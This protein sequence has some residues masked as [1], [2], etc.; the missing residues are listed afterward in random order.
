MLPA[1][2]ALSPDGRGAVN[3]HALLTAASLFAAVFWVLRTPA[4]LGFRAGCFGILS[5]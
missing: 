2:S 1:P 5:L 4:P 3:V